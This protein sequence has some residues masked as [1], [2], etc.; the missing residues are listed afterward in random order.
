VVCEIFSSEGNYVQK[1]QVPTFKIFVGW[2]PKKAP[3]VP[4]FFGLEGTLKLTNILCQKNETSQAIFP[5]TCGHG[6]TK[7]LQT[8]G[9][10]ETTLA[11]GPQDDNR[12]TYQA[13]I[14]CSLTT[15][16]FQKHT[17]LRIKHLRPPSPKRPV[18]ELS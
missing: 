5:Y 1:M 18:A 13:I 8:S 7:I 4:S 3:K 11:T 9:G 12:N 16:V 15:E 10:R 2:R 17:F 14:L 6:R